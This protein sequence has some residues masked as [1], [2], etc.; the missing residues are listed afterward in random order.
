MRCTVETCVRGAPEV[1]FSVDLDEG[2][3]SWEGGVVECGD[4]VFACCEGS[5]AAEGGV[6]VGLVD[7]RGDV[8]WSCD[9][10]FAE[11]E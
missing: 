2:V 1:R 7:G 3:E 8:L 5:G 10:G 9:A 11:D 6:E 4:G